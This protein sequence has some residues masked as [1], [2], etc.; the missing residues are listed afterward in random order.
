LK[1]PDNC[2]KA[3]NI[4]DVSAATAKLIS[5][6]EGLAPLDKEEFARELFRR[7]PPL[8]SG[9][10]DD[11]LVAAAGDQLAAIIQQDENDAQAR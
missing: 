4:Y 9:S 1:S 8:D 2:A 7:L 3:V 11:D 10:L 6:F 5:E